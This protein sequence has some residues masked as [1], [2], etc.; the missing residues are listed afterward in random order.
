MKRSLTW[1][2]AAAVLCGTV[3]AGSP[4]EPA[5][6]TVTNTRGD[7]ANAAVPGIYYKEATLRFTNCVM[8]AG[9]STNS[10]RQGLDGVT[11]TVSMGTAQTN[12][13]YSATATDTNGVWFCD[14]TVPSFVTPPYVQV[15]VTDANTNTYIY[16][17]KSLSTIDSM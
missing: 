1:M 16:P 15:K 10:A 13:D 9:S 11:I 2:C 17:W 8:F 6:V 7:S 5:T 14:V 3:I 4:V 12:I